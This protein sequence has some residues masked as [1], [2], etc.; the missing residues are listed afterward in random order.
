[1]ATEQRKANT[2]D[3]D[4]PPSAEWLFDY[5]EEEDWTDMLDAQGLLACQGCLGYGTECH[6]YYIRHVVPQ[7]KDHD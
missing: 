5:C 3:T 1:M 4:N 7:E 6:A 2:F